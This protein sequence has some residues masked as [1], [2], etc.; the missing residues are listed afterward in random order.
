MLVAVT[1]IAATGA[2]V[3]SQILEP[4]SMS[5]KATSRLVIA[6]VVFAQND[7]LVKQRRRQVQFHLDANAYRLADENGNFLQASWKGGGQYAVSLSYDS[8]FKGVEFK[9]VDFGGTTMLSF[10]DLGA[11]TAGD[12][13]ELASPMLRYRVNITPF[14]RR[15]TIKPIN[16][17]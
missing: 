8:R 14:T 5:T 1:I 6:D 15:V 11:P 13:V 16:G 9:N 17:T 2:I 10:D 4:S 3:I 7:T 12:S